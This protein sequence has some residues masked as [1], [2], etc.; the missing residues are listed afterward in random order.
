MP[1]GAVLLIE[2]ETILR[3]FP[4]LRACWALRGEQALVPI[5][6]EN[7]KRVLFG[8]LNPRT[9]HRIL[10]RAQS[11]RQEAFQAF[12][13]LLRQRYGGR[14]IWMVLD[15]ASCHTAKA[16]R[17]LAAELDIMLIWLPK[18]CSELNSMDHLWRELKGKLAANRQFADI[19]QGARQAEKWLLGL[20][21][22]QAL[23]KAG[24]LSKNFWLKVFCQ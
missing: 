11:M 13:Q 16:S 6:G 15:E 17:R 12:L 14:S 5:T 8:V 2:D 3:L 24:V 18:Q 23:C 10:M 4:P 22:T 19:D 20:T 1:A 21:K 9:G 7:A